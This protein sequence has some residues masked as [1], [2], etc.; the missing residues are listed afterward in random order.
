MVKWILKHREYLAWSFNNIQPK[1]EWIKHNVMILPWNVLDLQVLPN[2]MKIKLIIFLR[3]TTKTKTIYSNWKTLLSFIEM[4]LYQ[5][6][7]Q[8]G[9]IWEVL[10]FRVILN[11]VINPINSWIKIKYLEILCL[12]FHKYMICCLD[13]LNRQKLHL[14]LSNYLRDY[15]YLGICNSKS[16]RSILHNLTSVLSLILKI[17]I[18]SFIS[19]TSLNIWHF[20]R[21]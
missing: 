13:Y 21:N 12:R 11:L 8:F 9:L 4:L 5:E 7:Q 10:E 6:L 2:F 15:L 20:H 3:N 16:S 14:L 1:E 17:S 19:W 18:H